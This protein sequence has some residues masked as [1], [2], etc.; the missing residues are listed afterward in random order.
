MDWHQL[1]R[2]AKQYEEIAIIGRGAYGTVY[3]ARNTQK[4]DEIVA[5]KQITVQASDE[6]MPMGMLRE[7][8]M[9]R[10]LE[11]HDHPNIVKLLDICPGVRNS[12]ET[13]LYLVFEYIDQD[14]AQ[15]L[16]RYPPPG[17][18]PVTIQGLMHQIM[19]GVDFLHEHRIVHRDLKPQNI[20][21]SKSGQVKLADFGLARVFSF[22]MALTSVVVTLWYRA[23][24]VILQGK[25]DTSIDL[26]SCGCIFAELYTR[27]PLFPGNSDGDQLK[28]IFNVIGMPGQEEWP[29]DMTLPYASLQ[30]MVGSSTTSLDAIL[31]DIEPAALNLIK[32]MLLFKAESRPSAAAA[33]KHSYF[34]PGSCCENS[35]KS[36]L[37]LSLKENYPQHCSP[38][39]QPFTCLTNSPEGAT[40]NDLHKIEHVETSEVNMSN[41]NTDDSMSND[42]PDTDDSNVSLSSVNELLG[43]FPGGQMLSPNFSTSPSRPTCTVSAA[44]ENLLQCFEEHSPLT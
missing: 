43:V 14:L 13:K 20:L 38:E 12:T 6:G 27:K 30:N 31:G 15:Y 11:S 4:D 5:L 35:S 42:I 3:K 28:K 23:P 1:F 44:E 17:L 37:P 32:K 41:E 36:P 26:W 33:L 22:Q 39:S 2:S 24:E 25:Y 21:I 8:A 18:S 16:D 9:L 7:I 40:R 19:S 29:E 10:K 34:N